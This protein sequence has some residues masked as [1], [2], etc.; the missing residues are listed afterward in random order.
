MSLVL[1]A[2]VTTLDDGT[3]PEKKDAD[4]SFGIGLHVPRYTQ[5]L[6]E[7]CHQYGVHPTERL[8]VRRHG[9]SSSWIRETY[10]EPCSTLEAA[11]ACKQWFQPIWGLASP[12]CQSV[13]LLSKAKP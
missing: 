2:Q 13:L 10:D 12:V 7:T 11:Q 3:G 1:K 9:T 5:L 8:M 6:A 4:I